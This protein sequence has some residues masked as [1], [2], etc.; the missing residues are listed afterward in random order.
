MSSPYNALS[1]RNFIKLSSAAAGAFVFGA[2]SILRAQNLG[3][4]LN[5]AI[6]GCGGQAAGRCRE[7]I[8][9]NENIVALC[10][11][12]AKQLA[13]FR[14]RVAS[15]LSDKSKAG[16]L[17]AAKHYVD[18]REM[19]EKEK[20]LDAV[21]IATPDHWHAQIVRDAMKA[22]KH[23]FCE[24]PLTRTVG[25]AREMRE[26]ARAS[27]V[28][29]QMG[30]QGSASPD[31]RRAIEV[32]QAGA[33]GRVTAV[34]A[35]ARGPG[36][37]PGAVP[38]EGGDPIPEGLHWDA[39]CGVAA[40]HPFKNGLYHPFKWRGWLDY[41]GGSM[42]DFG[43]HNL[44]LPV[45][46]LR[47]DYPVR[48]VPQGEKMTPGCATYPGNVRL[49][50][51]FPAVGDRPALPVCWYDGSCLPDLALAPEVGQYFGEKSKEGTPV[52]PNSNGVLII[53][54]NGYTY[55]DAWKGASYI[56]LKGDAK[57]MGLQNH[58]ALKNIPAT[59]PRCKGHINEWV[60]ACKGIGKTFSDHDTGG[61]LTEIALA[62]VVALR[63]ARE[64]EWD[65][66]AMKAK[67]APEADRYIHSKDREGWKV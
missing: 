32:I 60:D 25:E 3:S 57:L 46:A 22:G 21:L 54:E 26:L 42:G 20:S 31:L 58:P 2:P 35:W 65:G 15:R 51:D 39:W 36:S 13:S 38:P 27:K 28:V 43:C 49:R 24:K 66:P 5:I 18:Y 50:F 9:T 59:L 61:H 34:H 6:I 11:V 52:W 62:G 40:L 45:R 17:D 14:E 63:T 64:L 67:N 53:G 30:N 4:K 7:L 48:I 44:N 29:T 55:G 1:R 8:S 33:L 47:L 37:L 23:V 41:G 16:A 56:K 10:D 19:L 12:D